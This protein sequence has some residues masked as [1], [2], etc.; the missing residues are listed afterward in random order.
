ML[1]SLAFVAV[2]QQQDD[3]ARPLPFRFRRNDEL[4]DDGLRAIR[5]IAELRFPQAKHVRVIERIAV[6]EPEHGR[7]GEQAVVN[8]DARLF[9]REMEQRKVRLARFR[10]VKKRVPMAEC[11]APAVLAR[12]PHRHAFEQ[13]RTESERFGIMPIRRGRLPRKPRAADR[14]RSVSLSA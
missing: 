6:I 2:R 5:E 3:A 13:Q 4:I 9:R 1:R 11:P 10:I 7:F 12:K 14:A 8:A